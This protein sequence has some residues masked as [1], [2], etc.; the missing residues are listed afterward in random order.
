MHV[1]LIPDGNRRFMAKRRIRGL[2]MSYDMGINKFYDFLDWCYELKVSEVT[3]YAL[4]LEN[5]LNRDRREIETLLRVFNRH[6]V[7]GINDKKLHE[8]R[9][10]VNF[11]GDK[12]AILGRFAKSGLAREMIANLTKLQEKTKDYR[13]LTLNLAIG[14]GGRQEILNAVRQMVSKGAKISEANL[15]RHLWVKSD[16]DLIIRT[17]EERLSNFLMWQSAYSEIYF[18]PKL[19]QEFRKQ[20]LVGV[21]EKYESSERRYGG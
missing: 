18:V 15:R 8:N 12:R 14:Y 21:L 16:P 13:N 3:L 4:S 7:K 6:A 10:R 2:L 1:G 11:C 17:S 5:L 20:D 9:V 19:W